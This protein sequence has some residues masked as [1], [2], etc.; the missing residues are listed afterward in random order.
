MVMN[1]IKELKIMKTKFDLIFEEIMKDTTKEYTNFL[2]ELTIKEVLDQLKMK[3]QE[4]IEFIGEGR[5]V[6]KYNNGIM[7]QIKIENDGKISAI[8]E[9]ET[10]TGKI[11]VFEND[12]IFIKKL[13]DFSTGDASILIDE[14]L[15]LSEDE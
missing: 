11:K 1:N 13:N 4:P 12:D 14:M 9:R 6:W 2:E 3:I 7:C 15:E 10:P 8:A 5:F